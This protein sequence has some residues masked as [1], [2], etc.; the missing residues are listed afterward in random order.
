MR[1]KIL[2]SKIVLDHLGRGYPNRQNQGIH[3]SQVETLHATSLQVAFKLISVNL[4]NLRH[5]CSNT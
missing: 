3:G 4:F 2:D 5:Q 1:F